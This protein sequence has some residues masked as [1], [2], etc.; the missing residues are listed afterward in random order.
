LVER[1]LGRWRYATLF[2]G[3]GVF[4]N[5]TSLALQDPPRV[6]SGASG[7]IFG[8]YGAL[9]AF[10]WRER[11]RIAPD[12]Y[13]W[14]STVAIAFSVLMLVVG[15]FIPSMDNAAHAGGLLAGMVLANL[16]GHG[17]VGRIAS[18]TQ[19]IFSL[20]GLLAGAAIVAVFLGLSNP[21][22]RYS[23]ELTARAAIQQFVT[24][25]KAITARW[26]ALRTSDSDQSFDHIAGV[27]NQEVAEPYQRSFE[28]LAKVEGG[29]NVPSKALLLQMQAYAER[30]RAQA[31]QDVQALQS[32][33][34]AQG[35]PK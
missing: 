14:I 24:Q 25:D 13:R 20:S 1:L 28:A 34:D 29:A 19:T 21:P 10:L 15:I 22:Y 9:I 27:L 30:R 6:S 32:A 33:R 31:L 3:S 4:G 12:E 11:G 18:R 23:E 26:N 16:L 5:L 2:I 17:P 35:T 7:A 8:L